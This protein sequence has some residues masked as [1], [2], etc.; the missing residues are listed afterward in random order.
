[1]DVMPSATGTPP[2][3]CSNASDGSAAVEMAHAS[4][5]LE[6]LGAA[7]IVDDADMASNFSGVAEVVH[8]DIQR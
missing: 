4:R 2:I 3:A 5:D 6:D 7:E 1:V 8:A